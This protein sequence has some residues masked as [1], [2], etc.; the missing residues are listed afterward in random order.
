MIFKTWFFCVYKMLLFFFCFFLSSDDGEGADGNLSETRCCQ[1]PPPMMLGTQRVQRPDS[2]YCLH[3]LLASIEFCLCPH[4]C[5]SRT[6]P[7]PTN[8]QASLL[9]WQPVIFYHQQLCKTQT[10]LYLMIRTG[11]RHF[12]PHCH[13]FPHRAWL[14]SA[15]AVQEGLW[16]TLK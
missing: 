2:G 9:K 10:F 6:E 15:C 7:M 5:F 8:K 13:S 3:S 14:I 16:S 12:M 11:V 1:T 4:V